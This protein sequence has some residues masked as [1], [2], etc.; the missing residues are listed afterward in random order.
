MVIPTAT[1]KDPPASPSP[2]ASLL[3]SVPW[4]DLPVIPTQISARTRE[5]YAKGLE[6]GQNPHVFARIGD[7]A[8]AAPD[9]LVG[10]DG[11]YNLGA[12]TALQPAIDYFHGSFGRASVAAKGGMNSA[13]LLTTLWTDKPC[14]SNEDLLDC[15][16]RLNRPSFAFIAI[17]TNEAYYLHNQPGEFEH[18]LRT[19]LDD[20]IA[21]GIVPILATK[22]DN[23]EGDESVN[24]TI[25]Q[26]AQEYQVPLWNFWRAA[27]P[28]PKH[29]LILPE[30]LSTVSYLNFT[31]FSLPDSLEYGM[32]VRNLTALEMLDFLRQNLAEK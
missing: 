10:F 3:S 15:E 18:N 20:T 30:H 13:G 11:P 4:Q 22:A 32:Q 9:F 31:D 6:M 1:A 8:S 21:K 24:A 26:L 16:Y 27:Q 28:L 29:G 7:C 23:V 12:Y 14:Q 25:A 17:G 19:I 2:T 5:I